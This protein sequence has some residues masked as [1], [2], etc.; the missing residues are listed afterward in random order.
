MVDAWPAGYYARM[1][2]SSPPPLA[3][4]RLCPPRGP[5]D[6]GYAHPIEGLHIVVDLT[7]MEVVLFE[8]HGVM[9]LPQE[10]ANY[11]PELGRCE[12]ISKRLRSRSPTGP[13]TRW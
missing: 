4:A 8:D 12:P 2:K 7:H 5:D 1:T 11:Q 13:A 3:P 6:N 9:P 10:P